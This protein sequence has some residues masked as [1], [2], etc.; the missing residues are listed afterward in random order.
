MT[1]LLHCRALPRRCCA[2]QASRPHRPRHPRCDAAPQDTATSTSVRHLIELRDGTPHLSY[3]LADGSAADPAARNGTGAP[4]LDG[5]RGL[6]GPVDALAQ[7]LRSV[8]LPRGW[9]GSAAPEYLEYQ[10]W[11]VLCHITGWVSNGLATSS[12]FSGAGIG[13]SPGQVVASSAAIKWVQ[14]D[15]LGALGRLLAGGRLGLEVDD[16]PRYWRMVAE[17]VSTGGFFLQVLSGVAPS[18]FLLLAGAGTLLRAA[19][20][21]FGRPAFRVIQQHFAA[22]GNVGDIAAKEEVWEVVG[23]VLGSLLCVAV[24]RNL[25]DKDVVRAQGEVLAMAFGRGPE[26][27]KEFAPAVLLPWWAAAQALHVALRYQCMRVLRFPTISAKRAAV[28]VRAHVAEGAVPSVREVNEAERMLASSRRA[29][30]FC[31]VGASVEDLVA[32]RGEGGAC[33]SLSDAVELYSPTQD[34]Y[35]L[36]WHGGCAAVAL[37]EGASGRACL[38]AMYQAAILEAR[39]ESGGSTS[40][41]RSSLKEAR[42]AMDGFV[43]ACGDAGW[44]T[45]D[46][47]VLVPL[48]VTRLQLPRGPEG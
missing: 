9:P 6:D 3:D 40:A 36:T 25:D 44:L 19:A 38:Q 34:G 47:S 8:F 22:T 43:A 20:K 27:W 14:K 18:Y 12:L 30:E 16:D 5:A 11:A 39:G 37:Y 24:L 42:D 15:G 26:A 46:R 1:A 10:A 29:V 28:L 33:V 35:V 17:A 45:D 4:A 23:Q 7:Q 21:G 48:G 41:L 13:A 31:R 32:A 2:G